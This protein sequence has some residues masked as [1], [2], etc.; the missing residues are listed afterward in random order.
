M[1]LSKSV[2]TR[3]K[4]LLKLKEMTQYKLFKSTG[5]PQSTISNIMSSKSKTCKLDTILLLAQ[6]LGVTASTFF[7]SPLFDF[8]EMTID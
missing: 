4:E 5:V 1:E 2:A 8:E 6:G 7:D 3:I